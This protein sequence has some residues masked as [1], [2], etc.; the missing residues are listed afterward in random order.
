[1]RLANERQQ[2]VFTDAFEA[3]VFDEHHLVIFLGKRLLE[4]LARILFQSG[5]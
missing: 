4:Q 3:D 5:E 1:M 2:M